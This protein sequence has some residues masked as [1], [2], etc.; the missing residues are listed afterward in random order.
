[1]NKNKRQIEGGKENKNFTLN[2][3]EA[4]GEKVSRR[5]SKCKQR[6]KRQRESKIQ[7]ADANKQ[8]N[9]KDLEIERKELNDLTA[10]VRK[11]LDTESG[12]FVLMTL[13]NRLKIKAFEPI[14]WNEEAKS[15]A[16]KKEKLEDLMTRK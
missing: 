4:K 3:Q 15:Q 9:K 7:L 8:K 13:I 12:V 14:C 1:M 10:F 11:I 2:R 6:D 16:D 5:W